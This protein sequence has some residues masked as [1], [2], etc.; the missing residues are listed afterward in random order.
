MIPYGRQSIDQADIEAVVTVLRSDFL[1][2]G[3]VVPA[4]EQAF[5][6]RV[7]AD[8]AV[9]S[10]SATSAL[11][12]AYLALGVGPGDRVWTSPNTFVATAN[13]ALY[14]GAE[15]DFVDIDAQTYNLSAE[16]LAEKLVLAERTGRLPKVV[17]A[18]HFAGQSCDMAAL[19][20]LAQRYGFALVEDASHAVGADYLQQPVGRCD[21]SDITVFSF[22]PVKILTTAEGG[23]ASTQHAELAERMALLRSHG[24]TRDA[25]HLLQRNPGGWYYEQQSLGFNYRMTE[26]QAALGLSQLT[27]LDNFLAARRRLA[28]RYDERLAELPLTLPWQH[29]QGRSSYHLYP[30]QVDHRARVYDQLRSAGIGVN[31]HYI[32][33][34]TQPFYQQL[35]FKPG[36]CPQAER[37]YQRALSLPLYADLTEADQDVVIAQLQQALTGR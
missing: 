37:Y 32:P 22:H 13:A 17:T 35:G 29:P 21:F 23:L 3:P 6:A 28:S 8:F 36:A 18:V 14:C 19:A 2:Q 25:E 10:S 24:V 9:A 34:H 26:L 16:A 5:A 15:V 20:K 11:H 4:F 12:L 31:V 27:R 1:T 33:V 7:Q 30:I